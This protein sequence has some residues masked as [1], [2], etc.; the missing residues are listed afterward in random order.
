MQI[1]V[2]QGN[3]GVGEERL[4]NPERYLHQKVQETYK[5]PQLA[6]MD[7]IYELNEEDL[8]IAVDRYSTEYRKPLVEVYTASHAFLSYFQISCFGCLALVSN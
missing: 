5:C 7:T 4:E 6:I 1:G 2:P 3:A 8:R